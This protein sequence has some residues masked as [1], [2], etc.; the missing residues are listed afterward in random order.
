MLGAGSNA[1]EDGDSAYS[2]Q[3]VVQGHAFGI[4]RLAEVDGNKLI[5]IRNPW[6]R[7][8]WKGDWSDKSSKWTT[9]N[10]N[11]LNWHDDKDEGIFWMD[12]N[13][14]V[15]EFDSIYVCRDFS[16]MSKWK[17]IDFNEKW[18]G[19]YTEG[20]PNSKNKGADMRKCP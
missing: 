8:E 19:S 12:L 5:Q 2:P 1:H 17:A 16:D 15:T 9:R 20:L 4:L 3:G 7:G 14:Y 10:R 13:D 11:Q 6:G 18:E